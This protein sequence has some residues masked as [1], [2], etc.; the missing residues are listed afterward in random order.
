VND[1]GVVTG[2]VKAAEVLAAIEA[3]RQARQDGH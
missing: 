3:A 2:V 1:D